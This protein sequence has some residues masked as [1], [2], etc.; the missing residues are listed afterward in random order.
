MTGLRRVRAD[1]GTLVV[2]LYHVI[3]DLAIEE[4]DGDTGGLGGLYGVLGGVG[5]GRLHDVDDQQISAVGDGGVDLIGLLC[6]V[7]RAVIIAGL[8]AHGVKLFLHRV[9][10]AG[11]IHIGKVI[12]EHGHIQRRGVAALRIGVLVL[13]VVLTAAAGQQG[14]HHHGGQENGKHLFHLGSSS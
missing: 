11:D 4:D 8:D 10:D 12:V 7:A 13:V 14:Q 6:L 1:E 2:A 3:R 9:A 5:R